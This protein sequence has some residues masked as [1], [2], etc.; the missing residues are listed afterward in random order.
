MRLLCFCATFVIVSVLAIPLSV[1]VIALASYFKTGDIFRIY[2]NVYFYVKVSLY[3]PFHMC[4]NPGFFLHW[5]KG[6]SSV[7]FDYA[8]GFL[9]CQLFDILYLQWM[10]LCLLQSNDIESNPGPSLGN[11]FKFCTWNLNSIAAYDFSRVSLIN[12]YNTVNKY[13]IIAL[14]ETH[15]DSA[16]DLPD[17]FCQASKLHIE[18][19]SFIR[20]DHPANTKRG[21]VGLFYKDSLAIIERNDLELLSECLVCQLMIDR[22]KL[23]F[24]V[25]YRSPS[26]DHDEFQNFLEHFEA[27]VMKLQDE[28]PYC[29][30]ISGD[31]NCRSTLWWPDDS[32]NDEGRSFEPVVSGMGLHQLISE[33]THEIGSSSSCID[34]ILTDQPNLFTETGVHPSL[35]PLCHHHIVYGELNVKC[36][37]IPNFTRKIWDYAA[38]NGHAIQ[39]CIETFDWERHLGNLDPDTQAE[40]FTETLLNIFSNYIPNKELKVRPREP[41]WMNREVK[42][43]LL[44]NKRSYAKFVRNGRRDDQKDAVQKSREQVGRLIDGAK[45]AYFSRLGESLCNPTIGPKKYWSMI[46]NLL[47]KNKFPVIP[48][49][50]VNDMFVSN[51]TE[52]AAL[53]ND[54]FVKQCSEIETSSTLPPCNEVFEHSICDVAITNEEILK[55]ICALDPNKA[56]G[57][58][59][60]SVRMIRISD[61]S[62][63]FPLSLIYENCLKN[64]TF[65][66]IWK[67]ANIVPVHKKASKQVIK[68]YRPISL[69]PIFG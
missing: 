32:T 23:F 37:P 4:L 39:Q 18:G 34:L 5:V 69:L 11:C 53:F 2:I 6:H 15:L 29:I 60:I 19:Y 22:K 61:A 10:Y 56:H 20:R 64:K 21:G 38:A 51:C 42:N 8:L 52:K 66:K 62:L 43:A 9:V 13:D 16:I 14:A 31:F 68:N 63:L 41:P 30:I 7:I 57:W 12:A 58:D 49:L 65:P 46:N 50:I 45:E 67:Y 47:N 3:L 27:M 54:F 44:K 48:P 55:I 25:T 40:F 36:P 59:E 1:L 26:Q 28:D 17:N 33:P 35:D 24:V